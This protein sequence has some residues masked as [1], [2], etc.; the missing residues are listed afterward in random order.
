MAGLNS[1]SAGFLLPRYPYGSALLKIF[2][3]GFPLTF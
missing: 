3:L 2:I 1:N